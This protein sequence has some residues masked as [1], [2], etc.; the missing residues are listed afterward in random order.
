MKRSSIAE[1]LSSQMLFS[2]ALEHVEALLSVAYCLTGN[3]EDAYDL[4]TSAYVRAF[5]RGMQFKRSRVLI[6]RHTRS[7]R[8]W[9]VENLLAA[10]CDSILGKT[11]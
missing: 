11:K 6:H 4:V 10:Y 5:D 3:Q 2:H 1:Q 9:L 8:N 7:T